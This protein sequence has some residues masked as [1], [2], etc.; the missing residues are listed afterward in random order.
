METAFV[1]RNHSYEYLQ[2]LEPSLV[3]ELKGHS[4]ENLLAW[5]LLIHKYQSFISHVSIL[6]VQIRQLERFQR[7]ST[8]PTERL[9]TRIVR[10]SVYCLYNGLKMI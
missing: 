5:G 6:C 10:S 4:F 2:G 3:Q 8:N 9:E 7:R 1:E